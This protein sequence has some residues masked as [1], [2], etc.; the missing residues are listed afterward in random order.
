MGPL[1]L[2]SLLWV[3]ASADAATF[4][5][6][7]DHATIAAAISAGAGD[8]DEILLDA[9]T[10]P[11][12]NLSGNWGPVGLIIGRDPAATGD[13]VFSGGGT[14]LGITGSS[15]MLTLVDVIVESTGSRGINI[16]NADVT[17]D[18]VTVRNISG[19]SAVAA[20]GAT[21]TVLGGVFDNN[22]AG[23]QRGGHI[24]LTN[25]DLLIDGTAFSNGSA[26]DGGAIWASNGSDLMI[27]NATFTAHQAGDDGGV[28]SADNS[29]VAFED[30]VL[31]GATAT[32][33]GGLVDIS[34]Q[35]LS[36][37]RC[38]LRNGSSGTRGGA[39]YVWHDVALTVTDSVFEDN[40]AVDGGGA[41][42]FDQMFGA[43]TFDV[44]GT[45]FVRST[46]T[47]TDT[48]GGAIE[49]NRVTGTPVF[50]CS[51]CTFDTA[52][53]GT[54]YGGC[55]YLDA[56]EASFT[57]GSF[58]NCSAERGGAIHWIG[59]SN[60]QTLAV[61]GTRF[62]AN[63]AGPS[64]AG[65]GGRGGAIDAPINGILLV[66][67][68]S[69]EANTST[70][71][72]AA[73]YADN[74]DEAHV[75]RS[76]FC[77]N[78]TDSAGGN[79]DGGAIYLDNI[80]GGQA[81]VTIRNN[82]FADNYA[83]SDGGA[84]F[85]DQGTDGFIEHN[86]FVN[87]ESN[88]GAALYINDTGTT[89]DFDNNLVAYHRLGD[90]GNGIGAVSGPFS[91]AS[92]GDHNAWFDNLD[93]AS[94]SRDEGVFWLKGNNSVDGLDPLLD[95]Y[96]PGVTT[97]GAARWWPSPASP[98][99]GNGSGG[100]DIGAYGGTG[101]LPVD[102]DGDGFVAGVDCDDTDAAVNPAANEVCG[103]AVDNDC[104]GTADGPDAVDATTWYAD[105]DNDT[106]G[107]PGSTQ[108][109]CS[110]PA[111][112]VDNAD[113]CDDSTNTISP[114]ATETCNGVDDDCDTA[115]DN[116]VG[117]TYYPDSDG[118]SYGDAPGAA[119]WC[120]QPAGW[121][122][123]GLDCDDSDDEAFPG[124]TWYADSDTDGYGAAGNSLSQCDR[125][126]GYITD[127]QDCN[128]A[129]ATV[130]PA[131]AEVCNGVDDDCAGGIDDGLT[132]TDQWRDA[133]TDG[134]G[135]PNDV[136]NACQA[137]T[138]RVDNDQD[139]DDTDDT[140]SPDATEVCNGID[141]DCAGGIDD[142]L[143]FTDQWRDIDGDGYG[144]ATNVVNE[145]LAVPGY[146]DNDQDC[147][148]TDGNVHPL[149]QE[150]CNT[151]DDDCDGL[152]DNDDPSVDNSQLGTW[153]P[154]TDS[155]GFGDPGSSQLSCAQ[156]T[157]FVSNDT[158]CDDSDSTVSPSAD[159]VCDTI[160]NDCD[161]L[162][163]D[164]DPSL[165]RDTASNW[166]RDFDSDG[167]GRTSGAAAACD[168]P[169]GWVADNTDCD[170]DDA[171]V[172]PTAVET[173]YDGTDSDCDGASDYDQDG[174]GF[175]DPSGG[176]ADCNDTEPTWFPGAVDIP[177][178]GHDQDCDGVDNT[179]VDSDGDGLSDDDE[180]TLY[181]TDP[182]DADSDDDGLTDGE[183]II[184]HSTDPLDPD[185]D[186]GGEGD[187][188]EVDAGRDPN[189]PLDDVGPTDTGDTGGQDTGQT[190]TGSDTAEGIEPVDTGE[191]DLPQGCFCDSRGT[192]AG[193]L[194]L[195]LLGLLMLRRRDRP[196]A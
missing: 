185:T 19:G 128:D 66:D 53:T 93:A 172:H 43:G 148:D 155:D 107:D 45:D 24:Q 134:Y 175:D 184:D 90:T 181:G 9:G 135:D 138:G 73:V 112:F 31:D 30:S 59:N 95:D 49:V 58:S 169:T 55:V 167:Y 123:N 17:L 153:Y 163:D 85:L 115:I 160:D 92:D 89:V 29:D 176:G 188:D 143:T 4:L 65:Q 52:D 38:T 18:G 26:D 15:T 56:V 3:S 196:T 110:Q 42:S 139:C 165:D 99:I 23:T 51:D 151:I 119:L 34:S 145:C 131:A 6:P 156:P 132:F 168:Q 63:N 161:G 77:G 183:E 142:G 80:D 146:T 124:Q 191:L 13:V 46:T 101:A 144:D 74:L 1:L 158:D 114:D 109:D 69:F 186:G 96:T 5:V 62:V 106:H 64:T 147:L 173:W 2:A 20:N 159:E 105:T 149:A 130:N 118:D 35:Q 70:S 16:S 189:D 11:A 140:V 137:L 10:Y 91:T 157:G 81:N 7:A 179:A 125:P 136:V 12:Q 162:V 68:A 117:T 83:G 126:S 94:A 152:I 84:L 72:A 129:L 61:S 14:T 44:V 48:N 88:D 102:A 141:D 82:V 71:R 39:V 79:D 27:R 8:G 127:D 192:P 103:D 182:N 97:C 113:D 194:Y 171:A 180:T 195:G 177:G 41:I 37:T 76:T 60:T 50:T 166:Y 86:H 108:V 22:D 190:D 111:G 40:T 187:G 133:D 121:V 174:D 33:I 104:E 75:N 32:D 25:T 193:G 87:N 21:L 178:D 47:G 164:Q 150:I 36:F 28:L 98:L 122:A 120:S 67:D 54:G 170:D 116:G 100:S 78:R 57:G 154:D